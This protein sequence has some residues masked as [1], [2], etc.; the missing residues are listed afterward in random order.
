MFTLQPGPSTCNN[1]QLT[2][3]SQPHQPTQQETTPRFPDTEK[4]VSVRIQSS[5][6]RNFAKNSAVLAFT[7][8]ERMT[9]NVK[10]VLGKIQL[11][12]NQIKRIK[13]VV[14]NHFPLET[15]EI[16]KKA[17][18]SCRK[19]IDEHSR[20]LIQSEKQ[21]EK[22]WSLKTVFT[23]NKCVQHSQ[24]Y[25]TLYIHLYNLNNTSTMSCTLHT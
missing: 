9:S 12:P 14:F 4:L 16:C 2:T 8:Q 20:K 15:G 18:S 23:C 10:G 6:T 13:Q 5:L 24:Q 17:W 21:A 19:S 22:K 11:S 3:T 1:S 7:R 25:M